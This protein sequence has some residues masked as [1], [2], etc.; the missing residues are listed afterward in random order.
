MVKVIFNI[1][2]GKFLFKIILSHT[3]SKKMRVVFIIVFLISSTGMFA[4]SVSTA[5]S[6][7]MS[8]TGSFMSRTTLGGYGNAFYQR[9]FNQETA[10]INLERFVLF[11][12]HKFN[13]K[14][15]IFSELEIEDA[16]VEGGDEGGEV[17]LEQCFLRFNLNTN[18]Y[19][20][21][22]LFLPRIG[23]LN[24][25]HLPTSFNG[26]ERT[27]VETYVIPS[28]WRELGIGFYGTSNKWPINYSLGLMNGL[29]SSGFEH[30]T[31]IREGRYEGRNASANNL[32]LTGS[33]QWE[34]NSFKVQVSGYG[35]GS[36]GLNSR[37]S[38]SL[39]LESG[40]FG[41]PVMLG[42]ANIQYRNN[43]WE[44]RLL[45]T[46]VSIPDASDINNSYAS[47]TPESAYGYYA[48]VGYDF[49]YKRKSELS[50][51]FI[52]FA[53]YEK[54]DLNS[55][56]PGNGIKDETLNQTNIVVGF[57]YLP[58]ANVAIKADVRFLNTGE[59]NPLL[60]PIPSPTA[61]PYKETNTFLNLGIG[62]SF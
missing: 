57:N 28:T 34:K 53:R 25:N 58:T 2:S 22:G 20:V 15:S 27:L 38:D 40:M 51:Q 26:N 18:N 4:Q 49:F 6:R 31:L 13:S 42:E 33:V 41:T 45:G 52:A 17:A 21:A 48:E 11:V 37:E 23:I 7:M 47:N 62:F 46:I 12:G 35:G 32:A 8:D 1:F 16:K 14:I 24:E 9:D 60:N 44:I 50:K 56:I 30:G 43:G 36:V 54:M 61:P 10:K 29:N 3:K 19:L 59:Q 5:E 39:R 55:E